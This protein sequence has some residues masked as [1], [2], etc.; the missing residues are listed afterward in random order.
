MVSKKE[1][2][3]KKKSEQLKNPIAEAKSIPLTNIYITAHFPGF[4]QTF[5]KKHRKLRELRRV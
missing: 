5:K 1:L 2:K 4:L 3:T